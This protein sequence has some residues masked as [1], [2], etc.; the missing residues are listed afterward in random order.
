MPSSILS[1]Y[2]PELFPGLVYHM[3][4]PKVV[5]LI[6]VT[7]KVVI[8]GKLQVHMTLFVEG[9]MVVS[10]LRLHRLKPWCILLH[11]GLRA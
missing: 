6:F 7:G 3:K 4:D 10:P 9:V 11:P 2:E 8:T 1:Q 5:L